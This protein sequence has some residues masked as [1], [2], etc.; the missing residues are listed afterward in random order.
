MVGRNEAANNRISSSQVFSI[1]NNYISFTASHPLSLS[2]SSKAPCPAQP[3]PLNSFGDSGPFAF[4]KLD[5]S[6]RQRVRECLDH[7]NSRKSQQSS[8]EILNYPAFIVVDTSRYI[9]APCSKL[10]G[11]Y[12]DEIPPRYAFE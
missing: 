1:D 4:F 7:L 8:A 11:S 6:Y 12:S 5:S 2:R 10:A 3:D 9:V